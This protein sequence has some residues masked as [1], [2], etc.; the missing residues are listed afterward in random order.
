MVAQKPR[1]ERMTG[2]TNSKVSILIRAIRKASPRQLLKSGMC[3]D[4][5]TIG[6]KPRPMT[7]TTWTPA[8]DHTVA[9]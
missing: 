2:V 7:N 5:Q 6:P 1:I 4:K 3:E 8:W 9:S